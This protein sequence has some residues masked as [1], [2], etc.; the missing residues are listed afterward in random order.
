[1]ATEM[2]GS[3]NQERFLVM[4]PPGITDRVYI[5][6]M[7]LQRLRD[8]GRVPAWVLS[9]EC[10]HNR[11]HMLVK[12]GSERTGYRKTENKTTK[13][14]FQNENGTQKEQNTK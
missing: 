8:L 2:H 10:E 12:H 3:H 9:A 5:I 11:A 13:I 7:M 4:R 1:M 14:M 6:G